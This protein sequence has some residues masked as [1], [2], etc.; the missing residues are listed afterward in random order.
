MSEPIDTEAKSTDVVGE[1]VAA[2]EADGALVDTG[3]FTLDVA[4]A[5]S[6]LANYRLANSQEFVV[7]LVAAAHVL[8]DCTAIAF[9][10]DMRET[11]VV[12]EGATLSAHELSRLFAAVFEDL[13]DGDDEWSRRVRARRYLAFAL[14]AVLGEPHGNARL[15]TAGLRS[16]FTSSGSNEVEQVDDPST[17]SSL[18]LV[19]TERFW[20]SVRSG[21]SLVEQRRG[22]LGTRCLHARVPVIVDGVRLNRGATPP[23]VAA[24]VELRENGRTVGLA[25][26]SQF[27]PMAKIMWT[28]DGVIVEAVE[29]PHWMASFFAVVDASDLPRD[30]SLTKL[31]RGPGVEQR[32]RVIEAAHEALA[33]E[34]YPGDLPVRLDQ[35]RLMELGA[36][37]WKAVPLNFWFWFIAGG[38]AVVVSS[39]HGGFFGLLLG[40]ALLGGSGVVLLSTIRAARRPGE[41]GVATVVSR[42]LGPEPRHGYRAIEI[43]LRVELAHRPTCDAVVRLSVDPVL[44]PLVD[45]GARLWIR[46]DPRYPSRVNLA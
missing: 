28:A 45:V 33:A 3:R 27:D 32:L 18:E 44:V 4:K 22:L 13:G 29:M 8:P 19:I 23:A 41:F 36:L 11:R 43:R 46:A 16:S 34:P 26:W 21:E 42:T 15:T 6:K 20:T 25:G 17:V 35:R 14:E 9:E 1:L 38:I 37:S 5:R 24:P 7:L 40:V 39:I 12:F 30:L 31:Q 2:L 10:L